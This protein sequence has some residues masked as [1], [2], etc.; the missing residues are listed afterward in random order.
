MIKV[1]ASQLSS[2]SMFRVLVDI[3]ENWNEK[4]E[5]ITKLIPFVIDFNSSKKN[6]RIN[7]N[8]GISEEVNFFER[9]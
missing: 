9:I 4:V 7:I 8:P 5:E 3:H 6:G 2:S 1:I